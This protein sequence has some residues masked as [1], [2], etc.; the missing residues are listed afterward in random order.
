MGKETAEGRSCDDTGKTDLV[1]EGKSECAETPCCEGG[2][3]LD[4][5]KKK[6]FTSL[7]LH[8]GRRDF[9]SLKRAGKGMGDCCR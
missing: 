1:G 9:A 7:R 3:I 8:Y 2:K 5:K 6:K 4:R